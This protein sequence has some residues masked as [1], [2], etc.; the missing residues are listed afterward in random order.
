MRANPIL[1][2]TAPGD[3]PHIHLI[4]SHT[5]HTLLTMARPAAGTGSSNAAPV[6]EVRRPDPSVAS[7]TH[8]HPGLAKGTRVLVAGGKGGAIADATVSQLL[9]AGCEVTVF[10]TATVVA[11]TSGCSVMGGGVASR[12][13]CVEAV[14][15]QE[16]VVHAGRE[17]SGSGCSVPEGILEGTRNLLDAAASAGVK[18]FVFASSA[19]CAVVLLLLLLLLLE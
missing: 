8:E 12:E 13:A 3:H 5:H 9:S 7:R 10:G 17:L 1:A 2:K 15:G 4:F 11:A 16:V 18:G 6:V 19:G 14:A